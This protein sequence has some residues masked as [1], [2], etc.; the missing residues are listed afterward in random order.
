MCVGTITLI[1]RTEL[2]LEDLALSDRPTSH[3]WPKLTDLP[4][5]AALSRLRP[6]LDFVT[7]GQVRWHFIACHTAKHPSR[8]PASR[9]FT[10]KA[11]CPCQIPYSKC[12]HGMAWHGMAWHTLLSLCSTIP[13]LHH[14]VPLPPGPSVGIIP[15]VDVRPIRALSPYYLDTMRLDRIRAWSPLGLA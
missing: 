8:W 1:Q 14:T 13:P 12:L 11:V 5:S 6:L 7:L 10:R 2:G 9:S 4:L 3:S 15:M